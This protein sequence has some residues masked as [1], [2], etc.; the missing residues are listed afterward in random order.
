MCVMQSPDMNM[1][2]IMGTV[3]TEMCVGEDLCNQ[4]IG[5]WHIH[6]YMYICICCTHDKSSRHV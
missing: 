1:R 5:Q 3:S 2:E 4:H 6:V